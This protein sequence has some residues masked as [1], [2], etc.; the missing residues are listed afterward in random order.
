MVVQL[1]NSIFCQFEKRHLSALN[2]L[3]P[4]ATAK[5]LSHQAIH[6]ALFIPEQSAD[7]TKRN[8]RNCI[9][10]ATNCRIGHDIF[11]RSTNEYTSWTSRFNFVIRPC[12][13]IQT[14]RVLRPGQDKKNSPVIADIGAQATLL[15]HHS[16]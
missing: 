13:Y 2:H 4:P 5:G 11:V 16:C 6:I 9:I 7:S 3:H 8:K 1:V 14:D 15:G 12:S 10:L